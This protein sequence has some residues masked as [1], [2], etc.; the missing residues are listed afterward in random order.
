MGEHTA[1]EQRV[2]VQIEQL[3]KLLRDLNRVTEE[4][5]NNLKALTPNFPPS[6]AEVLRGYLEAHQK[7]L[8]VFIK[9]YN[10]SNLFEAFERAKKENNW[11]KVVAATDLT[12][13]VIEVMQSAAQANLK[14]AAVVVANKMP[15]AAAALA[16]A[17]K[18]FLEKYVGASAAALGAIA[19]VIRLV[20][21]IQRG[22]KEAA[23]RAAGGV[24][25][26][27]VTVTLL[28][29]ETG[30]G[31]GPSMVISLYAEGILALDRL[32]RIMR[33]IR[34]EKD[35]RSLW[36]IFQKANLIAEVARSMLTNYDTFAGLLNSSSIDAEFV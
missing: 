14:L 9:I 35:R 22:D 8:E 16:K 12:R 29:T 23:V 1:A 19:D 7:K 10:A 21:A 34:I 26:G 31:A 4:S 6:K 17:S 25:S 24:V 3:K 27:A 13:A 28:L 30:S 2:I 18:D 33:Q 32:G 11:L 20:T 5:L 15:E 36:L